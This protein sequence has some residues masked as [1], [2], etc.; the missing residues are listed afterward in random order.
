MQHLVSGRVRPPPP[1]PLLPCPLPL[2]LLTGVWLARLGR[3]RWLQKRIAT[4]PARSLITRAS[5]KDLCTMVNLSPTFLFTTLMPPMPLLNLLTPPLSP[6]PTAAAPHH[7][8]ISM[9]SELPHYPS[10]SSLSL[11]SP[12]PLHRTCPWRG[13]QSP[14]CRHWGNG[15]HDPG[16]P[17]SLRSS[18]THG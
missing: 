2:F 3:S 11:R 13:S 6:R 5:V 18:S 12:S 1:H 4:T 17:A 15:P 9:A 16:I 10:T 8:S 7:P 14:C